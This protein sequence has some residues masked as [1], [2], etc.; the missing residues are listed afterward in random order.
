LTVFKDYLLALGQLQ[1]HTL[2]N[3]TPGTDFKATRWY[4]RSMH[5][6]SYSGKTGTLLGGVPQRARIL[7]QIDVDGKIEIC[8][9]CKQD[10]LLSQQC[11]WTFRS[12]SMW[13]CILGKY[14]S[15]VQITVSPLRGQIFISKL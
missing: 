5:W 3:T 15:V 1:N 10:L 11:C 4:V 7:P 6:R 14:L 12:F 8:L 9:T 13:Q 2:I